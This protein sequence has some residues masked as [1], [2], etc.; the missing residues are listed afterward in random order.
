MREIERHLRIRGSEVF[1]RDAGEGAPVLLVNGIGANVTMWG[2]LERAM[3]GLRVLSFD[4]PGTGRSRTPVVPFTMPGLARLVEEML[5]RLELERVDVVG[6]SFGGAVAQQLAIQAP[7]RVRRLVLAAT[8]PGWGGI[9]GRITAMLSMG[10]PLRY[11]SR[12]FYER[13]AGTVGG[14]RARYDREHVRRLWRERAMHTPSPSGYAQQLWAM[15][16]W[17]SLPRLRQIGAPTM[18]LAGDDDPLV[19]MSN[20]MLMAARIPDARLLVG[21]GEGHFMLLDEKSGALP[22]IHQF[23][24]AETLDYSEVWQA[25][26]QVDTAQADEQIRAD[27]LGALPWGAISALYRQ[28][29][30]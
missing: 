21:S 22:A 4:A 11:Y 24:A 17:T 15:T 5:D 6:Y 1:V 14:G 3:D 16:M 13:T 25:A 30:R 20:A 28:V 19:P 29:A 12:E 10:T 26:E 2:P 18:I 7:A 9:P 8:L 23:L 27:G